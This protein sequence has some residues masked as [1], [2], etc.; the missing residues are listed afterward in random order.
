M[1]SHLSFSA[2]GVKNFCHVL[3]MRCKVLAK[4]DIICQASTFKDK[5]IHF[6]I[7]KTQIEGG[8]WDSSLG[9]L[10]EDAPQV[11]IFAQKISSGKDLL[12]KKHAKQL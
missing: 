8:K 6:N 4:L 7:A 1:N 12:E 3:E 9:S 5:L 10:G 11:A 2:D